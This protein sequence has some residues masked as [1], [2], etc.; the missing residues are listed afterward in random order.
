MLTFKIG[1]CAVVVTSNLLLKRNFASAG[2]LEVLK[3][4][5]EKKELTHD[6]HQER[7][8]EGLQRVFER[9]QGY[10]PQPKPTKLFSFFG[11]KEVIQ[12]PKGLYIYGSVGEGKT[13]L[14]DL[15][16]DCCTMIP[17]KSRVHFNSFMVDVH[18][19]IHD[20]KQKL[21]EKGSATRDYDPIKPVAER[22]ASKSWLICFDE[23]QVTDIA[24]AMI[25]KRLFTHLFDNGAV[26]VATSNRSPND[27]YKNGLQRSNF[28]PFIAVL[29]AHCEEIVLDSG[30]DYRASKLGGTGGTHFYA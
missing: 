13:M 22:I 6:P 24:D 19:Q 5:V 7:V 25:L 17:K 29:K 10:E 2:P 1:R 27:L 21:L 14:M 4:R 15:F 8:S 12:P 26:V 16:F 18:K 28:V 9:I 23:F 30:T 11:K 20:V 3:Q